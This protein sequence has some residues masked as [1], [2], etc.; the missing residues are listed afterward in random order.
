MEY[1]RSCALLIHLPETLE[2]S[3]GMEDMRGVL[4]VGSAG[5][6]GGRMSKG[7]SHVGGSKRN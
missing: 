6:G 7:E 5:E 2:K 1:Q 4:E 3:E